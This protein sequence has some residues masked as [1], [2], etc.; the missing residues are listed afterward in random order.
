MGDLP[1]R[2]TLIDTLAYSMPRRVRSLSLLWAA[3]VA[4]FGLVFAEVLDR[5]LTVYD[6]SFY[7]NGYPKFKGASYG[8][9]G[10]PEHTADPAA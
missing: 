9:A 3:I 6:E 4:G 8:P 1:E 10:R 2:W 7:E 5:L